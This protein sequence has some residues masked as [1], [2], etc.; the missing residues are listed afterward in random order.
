M[1]VQRGHRPLAMLAVFSSAVAEIR[2]AGSS[3]LH[4]GGGRKA[5]EQVSGPI[6]ASH[7]L[8]DFGPVTFPFWACFLTYTMGALPGCEHL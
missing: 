4:A 8:C 7:L 3:H 6:S 2:S 5:T 1:G